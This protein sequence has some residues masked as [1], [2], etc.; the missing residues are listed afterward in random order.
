MTAH[1]SAAPRRHEFNGGDRRRSPRPGA[2]RSPA[3]RGREA[4]GER[5]SNSRGSGSTRSSSRGDAARSKAHARGLVNRTPA[6]YMIVMPA[7]VLLLLGLVM[8]FSA[9]SVVG[10]DSQVAGYTTFIM[11]LAWAAIGA[12]LMWFFAKFD[13]HRLGKV[14]WFAFL[15]STATLT[16]VLAFGRSAY[17]AK[18]WI[19]IGFVQIQP[20]ELAKLAMILFAAYAL[21][22]KGEK[23][24][25]VKHLLIPVVAFAVLNATLMMLQPDLGS[26][27]VLLATVM[28]MLIAAQ[29]NPVHLALMGAAGS[30]AAIVL[31]LL[32]PYRRARLFSFINPWKSPKGAGYQVIQS[33]IALGSGNIKGLGLG[34]SKQKFQ[35]LPNAHTDFIFAVIGE[36]FG[37][38][39][40][41]AVLCLIVLLAYGGLRVA[42]AAP[43]EFGMLLA[44]GITALIT[45]QAFVNMAGVTGLLPITGV[46]LPLISSG[47]SS[48]CVCMA[49]LGMLL[50]IAAQGKARG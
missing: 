35:Y 36:E 34:M 8:V 9:G 17:G 23:L 50:N 4:A 32:A 24:R 48:L 18:R 27:I 12:V 37:M 19:D 22:V 1:G 39:G 7:I 14:S 25:Q 20:T 49:G 26:T 43:D 40:T 5:S 10:T 31:A 42:R 46:P 6:F 2:A 13:Y 15:A 11:Q 45:I 3:A 29:T 38:V 47:G 30:A 21:S 41:M 44:V 28:L 16:M 33:Y